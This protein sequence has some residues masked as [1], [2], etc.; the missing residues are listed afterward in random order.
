MTSLALP[1]VVPLYEVIIF[2]KVPV[3]SRNKGFS[4]IFLMHK[5]E[6]SKVNLKFQVSRYSL[7]LDTVH[8]ENNQL[9]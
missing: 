3:P 2:L 1:N 8:H 4:M 5:I 7:I 9:W 6:R